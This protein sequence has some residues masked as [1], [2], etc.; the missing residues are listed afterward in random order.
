[1]STQKLRLD[2]QRYVISNG[3]KTL[4]ADLMFPHEII[5]HNLG[6]L[7]FHHL[8]QWE[9]FVN[10]DYFNSFWVTEIELKL[11][12]KCFHTTLQVLY[13]TFAKNKNC[14]SFS[15]YD[16][17]NPISQI[18]SMICHHDHF[19]A[20]LP[21]VNPPILTNTG[22]TKTQTYLTDFPPLQVQKTKSIRRTKSNM[23]DIERWMNVESNRR[24]HL[25]LL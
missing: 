11:I 9:L 13:V 18:A 8:S 17:D 20:L 25:Q 15:T 2:F 1:M 12:A 16:S 24:R 3:T 4:Y 10:S 22:P 6:K 19:S 21:I 23:T 5:S 7:V 14:C